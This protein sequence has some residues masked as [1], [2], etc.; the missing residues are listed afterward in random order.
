MR[1]QLAAS[2]R[3]ILLIG[4]GVFVVMLAVSL[5]MM[6][7]TSSDE[8]VP[9]AYSTASRGCKAAFLLLQES[10]YRVQTWERSLGELPQGKGTTLV[11]A[12]PAG[13]PG[14][15]EKEYLAKFLKSGGR[16]VA[17][18]RFV[19][20][21]L[22]EDQGSPNEFAGT[23]WVREPALTPSRITRAAPEIS[24]V[25][26]NYWRSGGNAVALYGDNDKPAVVAYQVG[27]GE[28]LWLGDPGP[29]T[30]AGLKEPGNMEL[31]LAAVGSPEQTQVLWDEYIHGYERAGAS[32][33]SR[34]MI[35]WI[36]LQL[37]VLVT[38]ILATYSRRSGPLFVPAAEKRLS[39]LEFVRTLGS[40]YE[41][42]SAG[43]V[44]V[45]ISYQRF[46][47]LLTRRLGLSVNASV[48]DLERAVRERG[49]LQDKHFAETLTA[50]E[51]CRYDSRVPQST[52]LQ[53]VQALSDYAERLKL[54]RSQQR[55]NKEREKK[56]WK[57]L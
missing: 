44:A 56:A 21:Y 29:L 42:A 2:D 33:N 17:S 3:K 7:G 8:E 6:K 34:R 35:G 9:S 4:V 28:V 46:R 49:L 5:V 16:V 10:G 27:K 50:C 1:I 38:A 39:P 15:E 51:S 43:S 24:L 41:H 18:G 12:E 52:A 32:R 14:K 19:G 53:L 55:K 25:P 45:E 31:L 47:Y 22:P 57:P 54:I 48:N 20:F 36:F 37:G 26:R 11:L 23:A 30:N 40:L 13:F